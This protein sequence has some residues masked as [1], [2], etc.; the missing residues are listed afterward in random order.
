MK[1]RLVKKVLLV[2][3]PIALVTVAIILSIRLLNRLL[4]G[5]IGSCAG[6]VAAVILLDLLFLWLMFA[7]NNGW[8]D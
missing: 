8:L 7:E 1:R 2:Y 6:V 3:V 5:L 4:G